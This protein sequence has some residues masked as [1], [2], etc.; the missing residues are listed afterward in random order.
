MG[1]AKF[2]RSQLLKGSVQQ[3]I[4]QL[5][6]KTPGQ[7]PNI[8]SCASVRHITQRKN[9]TMLFVSRGDHDTDE[10]LMSSQLA[11]SEVPQFLER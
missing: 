1:P 2:T 7:F 3:K 9:A 10:S 11:E 5:T 8:F 4:K 6:A